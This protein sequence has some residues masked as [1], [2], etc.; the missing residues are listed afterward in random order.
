MQDELEQEYIERTHDI[1][2]QLCSNAGNFE[3]YDKLCEVLDDVELKELLDI[4]ETDVR[5][6]RIDAYE[7]G[8]DNRCEIRYLNSNI[9]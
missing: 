6:Q 2:K 4:I 7:R 9:W 1:L 3:M 8:Y 5:D